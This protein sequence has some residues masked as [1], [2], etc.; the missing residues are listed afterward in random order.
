MLKLF[1]TKQNNKQEE[2]I[3]QENLKKEAEIKK[4]EE[5]QKRIEAEKAEKKEKERIHKLQQLDVEARGKLQGEY[6]DRYLL[7]KEMGL[8]RQ[9]EIARIEG[10]TNCRFID[11]KEQNWILRKHVSC[12]LGYSVGGEHYTYP[13]LQTLHSSIEEFPGKIPLGAMIQH[14]ESK[15]L[16]DEIKIMHFNIGEDPLLYG[17]KYWGEE[18][19]HF[20]I[21]MWD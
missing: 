8:E 11:L 19:L 18:T 16:F 17:I 1:Q 7:A 2:A 13:K 6:L 21:R 12:R 9:A 4:Q 3:K 20:L 15:K 5:D 14:N 10:I